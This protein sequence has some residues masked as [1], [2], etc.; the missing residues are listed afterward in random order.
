MKLQNYVAVMITT[1]WGVSIIAEIVLT[2]Y[3]T[4]VPIHGLMGLVAG[5]FYKT[6]MERK[7]DKRA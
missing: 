6:T 7:D 4:P 3:Q 2:Q 1:L 5:Y